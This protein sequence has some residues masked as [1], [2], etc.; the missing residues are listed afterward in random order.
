MPTLR[1]E[2]ASPRGTD[3]PYQ[4]NGWRTRDA[5]QHDPIHRKELKMK[6]TGLQTLA[7]LALVL[8]PACTDDGGNADADEGTD[9]TDTTETTTDTT[10]DTTDTTDT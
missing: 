10:T 4:E 9:T 1:P 8:A 2:R 3:D 7:A 5:S 6:R